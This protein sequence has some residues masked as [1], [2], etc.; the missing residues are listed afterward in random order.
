MLKAKELILKK[1]TIVGSTII[2][3]PTSTKNTDKKRDPDAH[4]TK[5]GNQW[6]FGYKTHIGVDKE[7]GL[8]HTAKTTAA[9]IHDVAMT[10]HLLHGEKKDVYGGSGYLGADKREDAILT[11]KNGKE[12]EYEI[13]L[14]PSQIKKLPIGRVWTAMCV[15]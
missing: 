5:K 3:A 6:Y 10:S 8:V 1:G 13:N 7:T 2:S 11:N 9:N 12:I 15:N 14:K 4:S